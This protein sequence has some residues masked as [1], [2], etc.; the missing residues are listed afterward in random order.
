MPTDYSNY[1]ATDLIDDKSFRSFAY[2]ENVKDISF[3]NDWIK[4]HPEKI[5]EVEEALFLLRSIY[6][7]SKKTLSIEERGS[8]LRKVF[9]HVEK[10]QQVFT[11]FKP[12]HE[13]MWH[14]WK[15]LAAVFLMLLVSAG[16]WYLTSDT[17]TG[18]IAEEQVEW[19]EKVVPYGQKL[20]TQLGDGSIVKLNSG[21]KLRFPKLFSASL[22][23]V[24]LEGEAFFEV[25]RDTSRK[26]VIH[27]EG[28]LTT[29]LGT[30]FN[31]K[32]YYEDEM[33]Q[34]A[35]ATGKVLVQSAGEN[36]GI[37]KS[38][39]LLANEMAVHDKRDPDLLKAVA[40]DKSEFSWRDD[41]LYFDKTPVPEIIVML[42]RW[43]GKN[44]QLKSQ[45]LRNKTYSGV[46][47]NETLKNV[48]E[49]IK[50]EAD[51]NYEIKGNNVII[52]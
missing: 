15:R 48:L 18:R 47:E 6:A 16:I 9:A 8:E 33:T 22:R 17:P 35:V 3:W 45:A 38:V 29:V 37:Q 25:E 4:S 1:D 28:M 2:R 13:N 20:T 27:S 36:G 49:G 11:N 7:E 46:F 19:V 42:E 51:I 30:S 12:F 24:Y 43:F 41:I 31:I 50:F 44:I 21:S 10:R 39:T 5:N 32:A 40:S 34:V 26:F 52:Y 14:F 23:E